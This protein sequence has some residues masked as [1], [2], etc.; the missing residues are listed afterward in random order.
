MS[1]LRSAVGSAVSI[2]TSKRPGRRNAGSSAFG[3]FVVATTVGRGGR[4]ARTRSEPEAS[5][6]PSER[7]PNE[8]DASS[9]NKRSSSSS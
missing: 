8:E 1:A 9:K 3:R 2:S 4:D 5:E 7:L 6:A